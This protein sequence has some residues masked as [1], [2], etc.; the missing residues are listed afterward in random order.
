MAESQRTTRYRWPAGLVNQIA[1]VAALGMVLVSASGVVATLVAGHRVH[2]PRPWGFDVAITAGGLAFVALLLLVRS[3]RE[4]YPHLLAGHAFGF[5]A[6]LFL[7]A[8]GF[9]ASEAPA[10]ATLVYYLMGLCAGA[11][12][13]LGLLQGERQD[14]LYLILTRQ[15]LRALLGENYE[16]VLR[17]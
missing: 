2:L 8:W 15:L 5:A 10:W 9:A 11:A 12:G 3:L 17:R 16:E 4:R 1:L 6:G 7:R 13:T 14:E